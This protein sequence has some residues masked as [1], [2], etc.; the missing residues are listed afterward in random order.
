MQADMA[1]HLLSP[2]PPPDTHGA[3]ARNKTPPVSSKR[4]RCQATGDA[5]RSS[6]HVQVAT[7]ENKIKV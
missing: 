4:V 2:P 7:E 5:T 1:T 6:S 3:H